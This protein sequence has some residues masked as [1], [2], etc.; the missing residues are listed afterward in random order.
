MNLRSIASA[1][2]EHYFTQEAC[3][4]ILKDS[5]VA[6]RLRP[7][8]LKLAERIM[9]GNSGIDGRYFAVPPGNGL[10]K[11]SA[12]ELNHHFE[13]EGPRLANEALKK[14]LERAQLKASEIDALLI[15]TCTGYL[16]PGLSSYVAEKSGMRDDVFLQ[17]VVGLG[18]GA[19]IPTLRAAKA[20]LALAPGAKVAVLAVE[21]CSAAFYIDDDPGVVVSACLF[22]DAACAA[23]FEHE[24]EGRHCRFDRF[25]TLHR[26]DARELLR[27][28]SREGKLRNILAPSVP[29]VAAEAVDQ[30]CRRSGLDE[31]A[32]VVPHP[33]GRDV[34][35]ALERTL[36]Y[37]CAPEAKEV[38][39][40][41]GNVSSPSVLLVLE[42][43]LRDS[44]RSGEFWLASFGAGF[45]CHSCRVV[46]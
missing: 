37:P 34:L 21:V 20:Q 6:K 44:D 41:Y 28:T 22:G 17:D 46:R 2:P 38:L 25:D 13:R 35:E 9:L 32:T 11:A 24:G 23:I 18:C 7:G 29:K 42:A 16:C 36:D 1:H 43:V 3:W 14:A 19:A 15:C 45:S 4:N 12:S 30:L 5:E 40:R 10:F 33:G 26:P 31:G 27:F 8:A 39:R